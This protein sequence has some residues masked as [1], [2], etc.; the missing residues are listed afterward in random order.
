[1]KRENVNSEETGKKNHNV[2]R[3]L[4]CPHHGS[5][6]SSS[7]ELLEGF[8]P[9]ITIISCGKNN[10]YGHPHKETLER[11][12]EADCRIYRT[13]LQGCVIISI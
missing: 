10:M 11:L 5:R 2:I 12:K 1:M 13:D 9:D 7:Y 6:Y 3:I 8:K 4:K